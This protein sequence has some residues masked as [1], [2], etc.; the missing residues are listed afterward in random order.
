MASTAVGDCFAQGQHILS[1]FFHGTTEEAYR[2][3]SPSPL[4]MTGL[5][6]GALSISLSSR[7]LWVSGRSDLL[8]Q[9]K[10]STADGDCFAQGQHS[11]SS[12]F[13]GT[14]EAAHRNYSPSPLAMTGLGMGALSISLSSRG[15]WSSGRSDLLLQIEALAAGG[16]CFAQRPHIPSSF[17]HG[18][19]E[20]AYWNY[21]PSPLAMTGL[22]MGALSLSLSSRGLW[23]S[24]RSVPPT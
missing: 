8:T 14:T 13:Y 6:M 11:P 16:D 22:G 15:L 2:N 24:G 5:G 1:S 4:A 17:F 12:F 21:S 7:G 10:A 20:A 3:Y 9:I 18:T 23:V 19:H